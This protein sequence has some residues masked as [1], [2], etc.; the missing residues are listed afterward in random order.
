MA[1]AFSAVA[2]ASNKVAFSATS[3]CNVA[4][5]LV[6]DNL[7]AYI[8]H[9]AYHHHH[10]HHHHCWFAPLECI[11]P[12]TARS[13]QCDQFWVPRSVWGCGISSLEPCD[14]RAS[15]WSFP[16]LHRECDQNLLS[17][18]V[19]IHLCYTPTD[20]ETPKLDDRGE[21]WLAGPQLNFG[22]GNKLVPLDAEQPPQAPLIKSFNF[23]C[24]IAGDCPTFRAIQEDR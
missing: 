4:A 2:L 15:W 3:C 1:A 24:I 13:H 19:S 10:H 9:Q 6:S 22:I 21:K 8:N 7:S 17:I 16:T 11:A 18:Y 12:N 14:T 23:L 5:L 20:G